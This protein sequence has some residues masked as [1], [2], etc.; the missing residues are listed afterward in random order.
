MARLKNP[1]TGTVISAGGKLAERYQADGWVDPDAAPAVE[2][3]AEQ[4]QEESTEDAPA[5]EEQEES[6]PRRGRPA[7]TKE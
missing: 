6:A 4:E 5:A 2:A 1:K 7:K 3:E